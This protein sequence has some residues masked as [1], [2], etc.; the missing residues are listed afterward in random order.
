MW[1]N[2]PSPLRN[3][4]RADDVPLIMASLLKDKSLA[5]ATHNMF[6]YSVGGGIGFKEGLNDDGEHGGAR[7]ILNI[8]QKHN[9]QNKIVIVTRWYGGSHIGPKRFDAIAKCTTDI[10]GIK[11]KTE[12]E[13]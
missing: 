8:L 1:F 3:I 11:E 13:K 7:K 4:S 5:S 9:V 2:I 12:T 6:A 10:L